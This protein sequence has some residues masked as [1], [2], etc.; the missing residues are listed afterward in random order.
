[1][2]RLPRGTAWGRPVYRRGAGDHQPDPRPTGFEAVID[3]Y[4]RCYPDEGR[5]DWIERRL[6]E[7]H[8]RR[9]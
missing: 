1:M 7:W 8:R 6:R 5:R 2:S 9:G 3:G 4:R